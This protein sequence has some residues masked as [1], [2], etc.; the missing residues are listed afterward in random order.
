V[1][2]FEPFMLQD[3]IIRR[4]N[5]SPNASVKAELNLLLQELGFKEYVHYECLHTKSLLKREG[6]DARNV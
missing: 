1:T 5:L 6:I 2:N 3:T 4:I